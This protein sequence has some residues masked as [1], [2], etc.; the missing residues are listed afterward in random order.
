MII[1]DSPPPQLPGD[2]A[3]PVHVADSDWSLSAP[4]GEGDARSA[5]LELKP[6]DGQGEFPG[7]EE[8]AAEVSEHVE[9]EL[10]VEQTDETDMVRCASDDDASVA[11]CGDDG[12]GGLG[13]VG[14]RPGG[15]AAIGVELSQ[16]AGPDG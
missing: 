9:R 16:P 4:R 2:I 13:G 11:S 12:A 5:G 7:E 8:E 14:T 15:D 6:G 3:P 1:H 10:F